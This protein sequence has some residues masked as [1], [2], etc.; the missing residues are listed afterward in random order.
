MDIDLLCEVARQHADKLFL[1][2]GPVSLNQ[3]S[4]KQISTIQNAIFTGS[5]RIEDLPMFLHFAKCA[6]IPFKCNTLTKSIYPLKINEYLAAGLPVVATPFSE[7]M[8][9]FGD[10]VAL[11]SSHDNF[12]KSIHAAIQTNNEELTKRRLQA[13]ENNSWT[14]RANQFWD[15]LN[16][17]VKN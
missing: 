17:F 3:E 15:I 7:D 16:E 10:V 13:A 2:V 8:K 1:F 12:A 11:E 5:K 4:Q 6:V 14:A 9:Q